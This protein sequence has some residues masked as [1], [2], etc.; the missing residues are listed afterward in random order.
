MSVLTLN[1]G[2]VLGFLS[3]ECYTYMDKFR[4]WVHILVIV[5]S[6]FYGLILKRLLKVRK[7]CG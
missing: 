4:I 2:L 5:S 1:S 6:L 7:G 3:L